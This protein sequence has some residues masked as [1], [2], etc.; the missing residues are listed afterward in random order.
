MRVADQV[1]DDRVL[2]LFADGH[3]VVFQG[4]H[5]TWPPIIDFAG[6][7]TTDL[8]HPVQVNAYVTPASSQGFAAHY[9]VHDVFVLQVAGEK[10]WRVH[11]PV[12]PAPRPDQ[13]WDRPPGRRRGPRAE[14]RRCST[15]CCARRR[16]LPA[17]RLPA[18]GRGAGDV[19]CHLTVGV[20]PVTRQHV[21][22]TL[23]DIVADE[24][25]LRASLPLGVGR[26]RPGRPWRPTC[27]PPSR[28]WSTGCAR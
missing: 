9:D 17:P 13:P 20:H 25:A 1:A 5:R 14:S 10:R 2:D 16:A 6:A 7:L 8:G 23:L 26:R 3:T 27:R 28:H 19:S 21:L 11:P 12:L 18:R 4:L 15:P 24:P 22:E